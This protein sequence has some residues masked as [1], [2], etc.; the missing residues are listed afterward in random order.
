MRRPSTI[1][2][3]YA[4]FFAIGYFSTVYEDIILI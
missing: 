1:L 4:E 2:V 3:S